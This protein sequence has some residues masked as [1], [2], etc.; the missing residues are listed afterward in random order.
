MMEAGYI[1]SSLALFYDVPTNTLH[2][3]RRNNGLVRYCIDQKTLPEE[4]FDEV[5]VVVGG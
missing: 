1:I 3:L 4:L 2:S 5:M